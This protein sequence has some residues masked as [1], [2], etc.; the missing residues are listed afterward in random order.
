MFKMIMAEKEQTFAKLRKIYKINQ[1]DPPC[2]QFKLLKSRIILLE[3]ETVLNN[4]FDKYFAPFLLADKTNF[5]RFT[6]KPGN[7]RKLI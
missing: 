3:T 1:Y 4:K 6:I 2:F 7:L 5:R